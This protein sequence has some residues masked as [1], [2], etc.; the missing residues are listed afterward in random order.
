MEAILTFSLVTKQVNLSHKTRICSQKWNLYC[1]L[2]VKWRNS[3]L[4]IEESHWFPPVCS[5]DKGQTEALKQQKN[6]SMALK[7]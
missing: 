2:P 6:T 7:E 5:I 3:I 4:V 1:F